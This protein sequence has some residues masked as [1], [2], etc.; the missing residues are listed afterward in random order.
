MNLEQTFSPLPY[1]WQRAQRANVISSPLTAAE[2]GHDES[3]MKMEYYKHTACAGITLS[4]Q[5]L[6]TV[7]WF[8]IAFF[9]ISLET[10]LAESV[11]DAPT[12]VLLLRAPFAE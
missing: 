3:M 12:C 4:P 9:Q 6:V 11:R 7:A 2:V 5:N 1:Y 10:P 8:L